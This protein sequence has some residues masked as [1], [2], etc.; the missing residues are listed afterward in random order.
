M[1]K[2]LVITFSLLN[3]GC[4]TWYHTMGNGYVIDQAK[5][6]HEKDKT[7]YFSDTP[8]GQFA[9]KNRK[10]IPPKDLEKWEKATDLD[11]VFIVNLPKY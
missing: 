4:A 8:R 10:S 1:L 9:A 5:A 2:I 3:A 7:T 11:K 6:A